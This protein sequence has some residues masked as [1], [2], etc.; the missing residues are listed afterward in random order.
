MTLMPFSA[1]FAN[2]AG[3]T[4]LAVITTDGLVS[5][6]KRKSRLATPRVTCR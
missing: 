5:A 2:A 1:R 3:S 6:G 4:F